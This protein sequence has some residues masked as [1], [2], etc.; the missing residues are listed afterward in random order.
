MI[1]KQTFIAQLFLK[2]VKL[3]AVILEQAF[4]ALL[5]LRDTRYTRS[6]G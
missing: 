6:I 5:F 3:C 1:L 2:L 4:I